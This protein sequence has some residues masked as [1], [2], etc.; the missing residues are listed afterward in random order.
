VQNILIHCPDPTVRIAIARHLIDTGSYRLLFAQSEKMTV[1]SVLNHDIEL[2]LLFDPERLKSM[3]R[4][5]DFIRKQRNRTRVKVLP[6]KKGLLTENWR[7]AVN[8]GLKPVRNRKRSNL[9][10]HPRFQWK[11]ND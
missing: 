3:T 8:D 9:S 10:R 6:S 4:L 11:P 1:S 7:D 5:K 2:V